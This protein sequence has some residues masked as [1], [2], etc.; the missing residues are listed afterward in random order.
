M[1][2]EESNVIE[3]KRKQLAA[4]E[5]RLQKESQALLE[6]KKLLEEQKQNYQVSDISNFMS[7]TN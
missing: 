3:E 6:Q 4:E 1:C 5:A 7:I 2:R